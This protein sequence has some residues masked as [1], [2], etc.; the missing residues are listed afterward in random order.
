[1]KKSDETNR[2]LVARLNDLAGKWMQGCK[3][4]DDIKDM[5]VKEQLINTLPGE[6]RVYVKK[7][8][9]K[10]SQEAGELADDQIRARKSGDGKP[11]KDIP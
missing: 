8:K 2:E 11:P 7:H 6:I 10:T 1:V 5:I 9:P 4:N 3:T